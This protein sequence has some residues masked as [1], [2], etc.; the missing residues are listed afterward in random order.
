MTLEMDLQ[1]QDME[2]VQ[3]FRFNDNTRMVT[4]RSIQR[5]IH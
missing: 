3:Q 2:I 1:Y 5:I 4:N